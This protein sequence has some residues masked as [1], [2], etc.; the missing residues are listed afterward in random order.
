MNTRLVKVGNS[1]GI[2]LPKKL[3]QQYQLAGEVDLQPTPV[4]LLI[5]QVEKPRRQGWDERFQHAI[6]QGQVP[7]GEL[8]EGFS[9]DAFEEVE[10]QW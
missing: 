5:K 10:W 4:G 1:R 9:D 3:L 2:V 8:L 7:E 6:A